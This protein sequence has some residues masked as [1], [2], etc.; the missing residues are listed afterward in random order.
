AHELASE[1]AVVLTRRG[2]L[3]PD[4]RYGR[5]IAD[6]D[7]LR[8]AG[9]D[10]PFERRSAESFKD[11][12]DNTPDPAQQ[13]QFHS[14]FETVR[15]KVDVVM[16]HEPALIEPVLEE[17]RSAPPVRPLVFMVGHTHKSDLDHLP[18]VTVI[19]GGSVGAGGAGNLAEHVDIRA[20]RPSYT[21]QPGVTPR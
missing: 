13:E 5:V 18:G 19:N 14:W 3:M 4:G 12:Y 6:V 20:A 10:D 15:G 9:Y 8:V 2:R 21:K 16:V 11:R 7:G 1:G 17:L